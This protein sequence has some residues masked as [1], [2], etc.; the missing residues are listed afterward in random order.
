MLPPSLEPVGGQFM[1]MMHSPQ[2]GS[3][4]SS[5]ALPRLVDRFGRVTIDLRVSVTQRCNYKCVYCR[6]GS[7]AGSSAELSLDTY[8]RII[9]GII[10]VFVGL[11]LARAE[12][13]R[14]TIS[15][16]AVE[17]AAF[18][19]RPR[20]P[21]SFSAVFAGLHASESSG[22]QPIKVN[23]VVLRNFNEKQI[24]PFARFARARKRSWCDLS[25]SCRWNK[26]RCG[27]RMWWFR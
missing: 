19:Q 15:M 7:E 4:T 11:P 26:A 3:A 23:C 17:P 2:S 1:T 13:S 27:R 20:V 8:L 10:R 14:I 25:S 5:S 9:R 22:L 12:L 6:T 18:E 16:D 21:D 24:I